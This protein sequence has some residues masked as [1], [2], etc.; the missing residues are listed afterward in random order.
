LLLCDR[1]PKWS[2]GVEQWL[3]T[4]GGRVVRTPPS[5][6]NCNAYAERFVRSVKEECLNRIVPLGERHLRQ[7]PQEFAA[8]YHRE[9]NHQGLANE[10]I[11]RP[12]AQRPTGPV[13]RRQR[14]GGILNYYYRQAVIASTVQCGTERDPS[15]S[16]RKLAS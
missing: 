4:A 14:V 6:P 15:S 10:L 12:V 5:A 8:H 13:R 3:G 1:A 7:S 11:N 9:R 2:N 16:T